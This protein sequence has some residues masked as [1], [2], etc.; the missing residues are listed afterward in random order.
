MINMYLTHHKTIVYFYELVRQLPL[1][2]PY[3]GAHWQLAGVPRQLGHLLDADP[4]QR[5]G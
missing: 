1:V 4:G 3:P 5:P 2:G